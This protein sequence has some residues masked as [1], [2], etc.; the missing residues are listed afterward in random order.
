MIN[1]SGNYSILGGFAGGIGAGIWRARQLGLRTWP[2][3]DVTAFGL[4]VGTILGR[5][6]DLAI[7]EH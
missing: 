1:L 2:T 3:L 4:A 7:V 5:I 6:G